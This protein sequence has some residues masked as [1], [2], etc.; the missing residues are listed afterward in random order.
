MNVELKT[1]ILRRHELGFSTSSIFLTGLMVR[2]LLLSRATFNERPEPVQIALSL[3]EK[4]TYA[5]A[6]GKNL[7]PTAICLPLHPLMLAGLF[8]IFGTGAVGFLAISVLAS[9]AAALAY[10]LVPV[11]SLRSGLGVLPGWVAGMIGALVPI[12]FWAQT[13]GTF[14]APYTSLLLIGLCCVVSRCWIL[15]SL[16]VGDALKIGIL[17]SLS[18]LLNASVVPVL[19]A[20]LLMAIWQFRNRLRQLA[21]FSGLVALLLVLALSPWAIRNHQVFGR[22]IW[23][24]SNL[25]LE[26]DLANSDYATATVDHTNP[27]WLAHHPFSNAT[28]RDRLR[29]LGELGY[30]ESRR[31]LAVKWIKTH[32]SQFVWLT[33]QRIFFFWFPRMHRIWQTL[34]E[35][36][37]TVFAFCGAVTLL[38]AGKRSTWIVIAALGTYPVVYYIVQADPR[39]RYPI[40]PLLFWLGS[41]FVLSAIAP[42]LGRLGTRN[43]ISPEHAVT[44]TA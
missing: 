10:S 39:Y 29:S 42:V 20:W 44:S 4:G 15:D 1:H 6:F 2:L 16:G 19:A 12:S 5:D 28:E 8:H 14:E 24:R 34:L 3:V 13:M 31:V 11:L 35:A 32:P 27:V 7:G 26:L 43:A 23:T 17:A 30:N 36:L 18:C 33:T 38:R 25:G 37:L 21:I 9:T 22:W 40:E 41:S